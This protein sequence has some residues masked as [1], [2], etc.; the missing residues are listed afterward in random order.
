[1]DEYQNIV[2]LEIVKSEKALIRFRKDEID[3]DTLV[4]FIEASTLRA[5][6]Q[7]TFQH[8]EDDDLQIDID[9]AVRG[10]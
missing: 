10:L 2:D 8:L 6:W 9:N 4:D 3:V 5:I 1:M 7:I